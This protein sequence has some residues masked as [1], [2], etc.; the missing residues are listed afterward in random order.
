MFF[1]TIEE[2]MREKR[3]ELRRERRNL[4]VLEDIIGQFKDLPFHQFYFTNGRFDIDIE[5]LALEHVIELYA[6][7][8]YRLTG[9]PWEEFSAAANQ[10]KISTRF[11]LGGSCFECNICVVPYSK[12]PHCKIK[13]VVQGVWTPE[14]LEKLRVKYKYEFQC[15]E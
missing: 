9:K 4:R 10:V 6:G 7:P 8:I 15:D 14:E 3:R 11:T 13:Q 5:G 12:D 2:Y 1:D